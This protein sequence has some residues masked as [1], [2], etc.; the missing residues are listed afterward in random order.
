MRTRQGW[1]FCRR[2]YPSEC[3]CGRVGLQ[4][5]LP[6]SSPTVSVA[7][8]QGK[9]ADRRS[10]PPP[11]LLSPVPPSRLHR[12]FPSSST[13]ILIHFFLSR[14]RIS[15]IPFTQTTTT[16]T[17]RMIR[18]WW[19]E[20][21]EGFQW[22]H[23]SLF[24]YDD[25]ARRYFSWGWAHHSPPSPSFL[26]LPP[27]HAAHPPATFWSS[28]SS[29]PP[30]RNGGE[31]VDPLSPKTKT[32]SHTRRTEASA[33]K[34]PYANR[35]ITST[36]RTW[37]SSTETVHGN[38]ENDNG[39][40]GGVKEV[41]TRH[42]GFH[43]PP[44]RMAWKIQSFS[45][46]SSSSSSL[47]SLLMA[48]RVG[49]EEREEVVH[50]PVGTAVDKMREN[51]NGKQEEKKDPHKRFKT[52]S[53]KEASPPPTSLSSVPTRR[54]FTSA[55]VAVQL[56]PSVYY[57]YMGSPCSSSTSPSSI[58][59]ELPLHDRSLWPAL[60]ATFWAALHAVD[61]S[62]ISVTTTSPFSSLPLPL[63]SLSSSSAI[64]FLQLASYIPENLQWWKTTMEQYKKEEPAEVEGNTR[65]GKVQRL[66]DGMTTIIGTPPPSPE[67]EEEKEDHPKQEE[68]W[69][70]LWKAP[71]SVYT[72]STVSPPLLPP[73]PPRPPPFPLTSSSSLA[74]FT[75]SISTVWS[76]ATARSI[77]LPLTPPKRDDPTTTTTT[78]TMGSSSAAS[79]LPRSSAFSSFLRLMPPSSSFSLPPLQ[80]WEYGL[81]HVLPHLPP[82]EWVTFLCHHLLPLPFVQKE[83]QQHPVAFFHRFHDILFQFTRNQYLNPSRRAEGGN[84]EEQVGS[85]TPP[86]RSGGAA[87]PRKGNQGMSLGIVACDDALRGVWD[88]FYHR[89]CGSRLAAAHAPYLLKCYAPSASPFRTKEAE[90]YTT[91]TSK[92]T[93]PAAMDEEEEEEEGYHEDQQNG[94]RKKMKTPHMGFLFGGQDRTTRATARDS[95]SLFHSFAFP[96]SSSSSFSLA[97]QKE[98]KKMVGLVVKSTRLP[99]LVWRKTLQCYR[100]HGGEGLALSTGLWEFCVEKE[101][102]EALLVLQMIQQFMTEDTTKTT[103]EEDE[104]EE[105]AEEVSEEEVMPQKEP[106]HSHQPFPIWANRFRQFLPFFHLSSNTKETT[107]KAR[108]HTTHT[109]TNIFYTHRGVAREPYPVSKS[110]NRYSLTGSRVTQKL[111]SLTGALLEGRSLHGKGDDARHTTAAAV[112][113]TKP[114]PPL[115]IQSVT[116]L[117]VEGDL[118]EYYLSMAGK[119][120]Y[121]SLRPL[122]SAKPQRTTVPFSHP[123]FH[124][125]SDPKSPTGREAEEDVEDATSSEALAK[126]AHLDACWED[127]CGHLTFAA[128][129]LV[130]LY[131]SHILYDSLHHQHHE[132][133]QAEEK[134]GTPHHGSWEA[135]PVNAPHRT[136][137]P[138]S[139]SLPFFVSL[140][141]AVHYQLRRLLTIIFNIAC[142]LQHDGQEAVRCLQCLA[143]LHRARLAS[144][145]WWGVEREKGNPM[146]RPHTRKKLKKEKEDGYYPHTAV[147]IDEEE[148]TSRSTRRSMQTMKEKEVEEGMSMEHATC[149]FSGSVESF[150]DSFP[151]SIK[152]HLVMMPLPFGAPPPPSSS[153]LSSEK[154]IPE[155]E[156]EKGRWNTA[157]LVKKKKLSLLSSMTPFCLTFFYL[158]P[159]STSSLSLSPPDLTQSCGRKRPR[160]GWVEEEASMLYFFCQQS[161]ALHNAVAPFSLAYWWWKTMKDCCFEAFSRKLFRFSLR[162]ATAWTDMLSVVMWMEALEWEEKGRAAVAASSFEAYVHRR[163]TRAPE[164]GQASYEEEEMGVAKEERASLTAAL[165]VVHPKEKDKTN[166]VNEIP[167]PT[168]PE[169]VREEIN[170]KRRALLRW[171][172]A[173][174][175]SSW[176]VF[177][178]HVL[179]HHQPV[180]HRHDMPPP[181]EDPIHPGAVKRSEWMGANTTTT[182]TTHGSSSQ[183]STLPV[184]STSSTFLPC[185]EYWKSF[186]FSIRDPS[187]E[188]LLYGFPVSSTALAFPMQPNDRK[189]NTSNVDDTTHE[190]FSLPWLRQWR[191]EHSFPHAKGDHMSSSTQEAVT[192]DHP[193]PRTRTT[194][195]FSSAL[196][197][198]LH[199][200]RFA[201]LSL[202]RRAQQTLTSYVETELY[203]TGRMVT[204][205]TMKQVAMAMSQLEVWEAAIGGGGLGLRPSSHMMPFR[206]C[207]QHLFQDTAPPTAST[208]SDEKNPH[209]R[210]DKRHRREGTNEEVKREGGVASSRLLSTT[211]TLPPSTPPPCTRTWTCGCGYTGNM[212]ET[213]TCTFCVLST[214]RRCSW[215]CPTCQCLGVTAAWQREREREEEVVTHTLDHAASF[216]MPPRMEPNTPYCLACGALHPCVGVVAGEQ[217]HV[218]PLKEKEEATEVQGARGIHN[219]EKVEQ[220][221]PTSSEGEM[222]STVSDAPWPSPEEVQVKHSSYAVLLP[223]VSHLPREGPPLLTT[224][225]SSLSSSLWFPSLSLSPSLLRCSS[226][227]SFHNG[228]AYTAAEKP[229]IHSRIQ[230]EHHGEEKRGT[231]SRSSSPEASVKWNAGYPDEDVTNLEIHLEGAVQEAEDGCP[232]RILQSCRVWGGATASPHLHPCM[233]TKDSSCGSGDTSTPHTSPLEVLPLSPVVCYDCGWTGMVHHSPAPAGV[234]SLSN[235]E[236]NTRKEQGSP[237]KIELEEGWKEENGILSHSKRVMSITHATPTVDSSPSSVVSLEKGSSMCWLTFSSSIAAELWLYYCDCCHAFS[238][239]DLRLG[240]AGQRNEEEEDEWR[241]RIEVIPMWSNHGCPHCGGG[242]QRPMQQDVTTT[243]EETSSLSNSNP[244]N[245][246][247]QLWDRTTTTAAASSSSPHDVSS[248]GFFL[249]YFTW[250][251]GGCGSENS[252]LHAHCWYCTRMEWKR[253]V[254]ALRGTLPCNA[255]PWS[256]CRS[257]ERKVVEE[258][259]ESHDPTSPTS[260][261]SS[262]TLERLLQH[263]V[264]RRRLA[265]VTRQAMGSSSPAVSSSAFLSSLV[266]RMAMTDAAREEGRSSMWSRSVPPP[267]VGPCWTCG[268]CE[269]RT[270]LWHPSTTT[271]S[272][273]CS[274]GS[275]F[276]LFCT[277][278]GTTHAQLLASIARCRVWKC[279]RCDHGLGSSSQQQLRRW[280][281]GRW[282]EAKKREEN[283]KRYGKRIVD[284]EEYRREGRG[285]KKRKRNCTAW[286]G[287]PI[288]EE[289]D[290]SSFSVLYL[291][292]DCCGWK[293]ETSPRSLSSL[294]SLPT[295]TPSLTL[296]IDAAVVSTTAGRNEPF[297]HDTSRTVK[298]H[299]VVAS[300]RRAVDVQKKLPGEE[301]RVREMVLHTVPHRPWCCHHCGR[302]NNAPSYSTPPRTTIMSTFSPLTGAPLDASPSLKEHHG[303]TISERFMSDAS[304]ALLEGITTWVPVSQME[305]ENG[306]LADGK[307]SH[308]REPSATIT[309]RARIS[310]PGRDGGT[311]ERDSRWEGGPTAFPVGGLRYVECCVYCQTPRQLPVLFPYRLPPLLLQESSRSSTR[312]TEGATSMER[313]QKIV[314]NAVRASSSTSW[315]FPFTAVSSLRFLFSTVRLFLSPLQ[316]QEYQLPPYSIGEPWMCAQCGDSNPPI[317]P[318]TSSHSTSSTR[319]G[320]E[321]MSL[322]ELGSTFPLEDVSSSSLEA[323]DPSSKDFLEARALLPRVYPLNG[324]GCETAHS[325]SYATCANCFALGPLWM[326]CQTRTP[327]VKGKDSEKEY[328]LREMSLQEGPQDEV[329]K[330]KVTPTT[331]TEHT[332]PRHLQD[333]AVLLP[334]EV[335]KTVMRSSSSLLSSCTSPPFSI[336]EVWL[337]R[338]PSCSP[339]G[340]GCAMVAGSTVDTTTTISCSVPYPHAPPTPAT[341]SAS[342][343]VDPAGLLLRTLVACTMKEGMAHHTRET[344]WKQGE[345]GGG[346]QEVYH[347]SWMARCPITGVSRWE[348][349]DNGEKKKNEIQEVT[350]NMEKPWTPVTFMKR[351]ASRWYTDGKA[352]K[353]KDHRAVDHL[354]VSSS[355]P[356]VASLVPVLPYTP[357]WCDVCGAAVP[358]P[359]LLSAL[360]ICHRDE[361]SVMSSSPL[362]PFSEKEREVASRPMEVGN[363]TKASIPTTNGREHVTSSPWNEGTGDPSSSAKHI[364]HELEMKGEKKTQRKDGS[365][366]SPR[367]LLAD[368]EGQFPYSYY[369]SPSSLSSLTSEDAKESTRRRRRGHETK[370]EVEGSNPKDH[371]L[372]MVEWKLLRA[373]DACPP[374][375]PCPPFSL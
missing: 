118:W 135:R 281:W 122:Q 169:L 42:S 285:K 62:V 83:E 195:S 5:F 147:E 340:R 353:E 6:F 341:S 153:S 352:R 71:L 245:A 53:Q 238:V 306:I 80:R 185:T 158:L 337:W 56:V 243:A 302:W 55:F 228:E 223:P 338:C 65:K 248:T 179:W 92:S 161:T 326:A 166:E 142:H 274:A 12:S 336:P 4:S 117:I 197:I 51:K 28:S 240:G 21:K 279:P 89:A 127:F 307:V 168:R 82:Y 189:E 125:K 73:P 205:L 24:P 268:S 313:C 136:S 26:P 132:Q 250:T 146:G 266:Q 81:R 16:T 18:R 33:T 301:Q 297:N 14:E 332:S 224:S 1:T 286:E 328:D 292:C 215:R 251:C 361:S 41:S 46:S 124:E 181:H 126:Q 323:K 39:E 283:E 308:T 8:G 360:C 119:R 29:S 109:T 13:N 316:R 72:A 252:P 23:S 154:E 208:S 9:H 372:K 66:S 247:P 7:D 175:T 287:W 254:A 101:E 36:T 349:R 144:Q 264:F 163:R 107:I 186:L 284:A 35:V 312:R 143:I 40:D 148:N 190:G 110:R 47:S 368:E 262:R 97:H 278:C 150:L 45:F 304:S 176:F 165:P 305:N 78:K 128:P 172:E 309:V 371:R 202:Q 98:E 96:S 32:F 25:T 93:T 108:S 342:S 69:W 17:T 115:P 311:V 258:S 214:L 289:A 149:T 259:F 211:T 86:R 141:H 356:Y 351:E 15:S 343:L 206:T 232:H 267:D 61:K 178:S 280:W 235:R 230:K 294:K 22:R 79:S 194:A 330:E 255:A 3:S 52:S 85:S 188:E 260:S 350:E 324:V 102:A 94:R 57:Q 63:R 200:G 291:S 296:R 99:V 67:K 218:P 369:A 362:A 44:R 84:G 213:L 236:I 116:A 11:F 222:S 131:Q 207:M 58:T 140:E 177:T 133:V 171:M 191:T 157:L 216:W 74:P 184:P 273:S 174:D 244:N 317:P 193:P 367:T 335:K 293:W 373:A 319:S 30:L 156:E 261:T 374:P 265:K 249:P 183:G 64:L 358:H 212:R 75:E 31:C 76:H 322:L 229:A 91:S 196:Q 370:T 111:R 159:R 375:P 220:V 363:L 331:I 321:G 180:I 241:S 160:W 114:S 257:Q 354:E 10:L 121:R 137:V 329:M 344:S 68:E 204:Q 239:V 199:V 263:P 325:F 315:F 288:P 269:K 49:R 37:T 318:S 130:S 103:K 210:G 113:M 34:R 187:P 139:S 348:W 282:E 77:G 129:R 246:P 345:E 298:G 162:C 234:S 54:R 231:V 203:G 192:E 355:S 59:W 2:V 38:E 152:R 120:E 151:P 226:S 95:S 237:E 253:Q 327:L 364:K 209:N 19:V 221:L 170:R 233:S 145:L 334:P 155:Q 290:T 303:A 138:T 275:S 347:P 320:D 217:L 164:E 43:G 276:P 90:R 198:A 167:W 365:P 242:D 357:V 88:V 27:R 227:A 300:E 256:A 20:W 346:P 100:E 270:F 333:T 314:P 271:P 310:P 295:T 50:T 359:V 339:P 48:M 201:L 219:E 366:S 173:P 112:G 277:S 272:S 299:E 225:S 87:S 134:E 60:T 70:T 123:R 104:G 105:E 182:R 106:S